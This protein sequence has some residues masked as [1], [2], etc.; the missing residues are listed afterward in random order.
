MTCK[1]HY[2]LRADH[3]TVHTPGGVRALVEDSDLMKL[4]RALERDG[5]DVSGA[6]AELTA[7]VNFVTASNIS[8]NDVIS[9]LDYCAMM[10]KKNLPKKT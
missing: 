8:M 10:I 9:H 3:K 2:P 1:Y 5:Y 6:A 4:I 7:L